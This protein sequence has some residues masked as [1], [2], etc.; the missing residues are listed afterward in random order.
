MKTTFTLAAEA[1][2]VAIRLASQFPFPDKMSAAKF[3][4]GFAVY[5][6]RPLAELPR[7]VGLGGGT[8]YN[9]GSFDKD[10]E[11]S[12]LVTAL[13][14]ESNLDSAQI[15]EGLTNAGL[16]A[17]GEL[18]PGHLRTFEDLLELVFGTSKPD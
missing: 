10:R 8:T 14:P 1:D 16:V 13:F 6:R 15:V 18:V 4:F 2:I 5:A 11:M 9:W 12:A 17:L 3:G 7:W